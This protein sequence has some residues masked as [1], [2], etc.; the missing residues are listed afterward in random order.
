MVIKRV[1]FTKPVTWPNSAWHPTEIEVDREIDPDFSIVLAP[2]GVRVTSA[3][4]EVLEV[5]YDNVRM[6][7]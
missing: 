1:Q 5:P 3:I 7:D 6:V 4:G 2:S